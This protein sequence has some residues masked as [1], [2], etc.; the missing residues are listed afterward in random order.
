MGFSDKVRNLVEKLQQLPEIQ[1]KIIFFTVMT[2]FVIFMVFF[3]LILTKNN[4]ASIN[5]SLKSLTFPEINIP[6][7]NER[8]IAGSNMSDL[9]KVG[10]SLQNINTDNSSV[11]GGDNQVF[12]DF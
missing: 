6:D 4:I 11:S 8:N 7:F 2:V 9:E 10:E 3:E 12:Q 5:Q 1:K